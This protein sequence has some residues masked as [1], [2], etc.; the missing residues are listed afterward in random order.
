MNLKQIIFKIE[1]KLKAEIGYFVLFKFIKLAL[2]SW[3]Y[4]KLADLKTQNS[5][6]E[7]GR[8]LEFFQLDED[9][10]VV[11][12]LTDNEPLSEPLK[13]WT[14]LVSMLSPRMRRASSRSFFIKVTRLAW[15][16]H[17][18]AS[19]NRPVTKASV[20]S[21]KATMAWLWNR[22][23]P[24]IFE[25]IC[26]TSR[27]NGAKGSSNWVDFWNFLTSRRATMPGRKRFFLMA[28]DLFDAPVS[29][30]DFLHSISCESPGWVD[31]F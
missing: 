22:S 18:W 13:I 26:L 8:I 17:K 16:A 28:F 19:S 9:G 27:W 5:K 20:D 6:N 14:S 7:L 10:Y 21:C 2:N 15:M 4:F 12:C 29:E 30:V 1:V 3:F 24:S 31:P 11:E 23:L 25:V